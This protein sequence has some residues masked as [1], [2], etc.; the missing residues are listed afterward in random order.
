[1]VRTVGFLRFLAEHA[2]QEVEVITHA[3]VAVV[4]LA[5]VMFYGVRAYFK[6]AIESGDQQLRVEE[7]RRKFK[8]EQLEA[9]RG[10]LKE[11]ASGTS[12]E[13]SAKL[14]VMETELAKIKSRSGAAFWRSTKDI[15]RP[16][17]G[18]ED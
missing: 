1:M 7:Q 14:T 8:D 2:R 11:L 17:D 6:H 9:A 13:L 3:P 10:Q 15:A 5:A 18:K 4:F 16:K 12:G